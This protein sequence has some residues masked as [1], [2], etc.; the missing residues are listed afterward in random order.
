MKK[1]FFAAIAITTIWGCARK[2][3]PP[4]TATEQPAVTTETKSVD[5]KTTASTEMIAA[6]KVTYEAKCGRCHALHATDEFTAERWV[7]LVN[8]MSLKAKLTDTEKS[9]VLAYVQSGAKQ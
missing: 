9:N 3:T 6:G 5:T 2:V 8:A 7:P 1:F 4:Q